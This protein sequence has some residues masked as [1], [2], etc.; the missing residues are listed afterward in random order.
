MR[1]EHEPTHLFYQDNTVSVCKAGVNARRLL[2]RGEM[3]LTDMS[4]MSTLSLLATDLSGS[5]LIATHQEQNEIRNY[6]CYGVEPQ[7]QSKTWPPGFNGEVYDST[8]Q[9]YA[10]GN[11]YRNFSPAAMRFYSP[12]DLSPFD[13]GGLNAYCY[14]MG[15]PINHIDP[16][17][18]SRSWLFSNYAP[19]KELK[20]RAASHNQLAQQRNSLAK[21]REYII[22]K[23]EKNQLRS[24]KNN[25]RY[26]NLAASIPA[27][28]KRVS[29]SEKNFTKLYGPTYQSSSQ[30]R[31]TLRYSELERQRD[32]IALQSLPRV[33]YT[34]K[35]A[36]RPMR[37]T[38]LSKS[39]LTPEE[40]DYY[41]GQSRLSISFSG[42]AN[43]IKNR[44]AEAAA[45]I[46]G[47]V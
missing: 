24:P 29:E 4:N 35:T 47:Q 25:R 32:V 46:R 36:T 20:E 26:N 40:H 10:L 37:S 8:T 17:G 44:N 18:H 41:D 30:Q 15:D 22:S 11:G 31:I 42:L 33:D 28:E 5:I 23:W 7:T 16:T 12:D 9:C 3:L 39:W 13:S 45:S 27:L 2:R 1:A 43:I 34:K 21:A 38:A 19:A 6:S 14:C